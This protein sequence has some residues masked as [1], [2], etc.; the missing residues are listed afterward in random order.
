MSQR[1]RCFRKLKDLYQFLMV[2]GSNRDMLM[3]CKTLGR[4]KPDIGTI[5][6]IEGRVTLV[7]ATQDSYGNQ[8]KAIRAALV[9]RK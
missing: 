5:H 2:F 4:R 6:M 8:G 3:S 1:L 7:K 9:T